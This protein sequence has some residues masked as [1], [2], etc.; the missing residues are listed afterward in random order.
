[1][2]TPN[3]KKLIELRDLKTYFYT[4]DGVVKAVDG[5]SFSIDRQKTLGVVGESGCGKSVTALSVMGLI[6]MPPGKIVGGSVIY[7]RNGQEIEL[8]KLNPKGKEYR[9]I[10]GNEI[11]MIFQEPMTSL[12]PVYTIGN[13]IMEAIMLHQ[14]VGRRE[15][16]ERA[17]EML[18]AVGIPL[19]EQRVDEYPHQLSGGMR[20]RA[21]IAMALSCN[22]HLLIADEP[23]TALDVTIQAQILD[24][25]RKLQDEFHMALMLITHNLGVV[26][27]MADDVVIMYMGK[28]V[29]E[30]PVR[31][32][33]H[34]PLHPYTQ[35]LMESIPALTRKKERLKPIKGMI[36]DPY[37]LPKGCPFE[38]RC[39]EAT[40]ICREKMPDLKEIR[41]GHKVAC[42]ARF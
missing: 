28:V 29:E 4:E 2:A 37:N 19:P 8:S 1:M 24:L 32:I 40:E 39:P 35:G 7:Y 17:I 38:P 21:M 18:K 30:A 36:P 16:R 42:W 23:T 12:N 34:H 13:Q 26:A 5:V 10:R 27:E 33:F 14:K 9:D 20:Q 6:P 41:P 25:I 31:E 3:G 15:A 22:P 11:A